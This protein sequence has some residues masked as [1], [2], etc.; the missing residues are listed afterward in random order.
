M[1]VQDKNIGGIKICI[2]LRNLNDACLHHPFPTPI[3]DEVVENVQ[4]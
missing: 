2:Y 3:I 1:V 4:G